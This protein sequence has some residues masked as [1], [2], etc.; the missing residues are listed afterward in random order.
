VSR[1]GKRE[2]ADLLAAGDYDLF[3]RA[4]LGCQI[5]TERDEPGPPSGP[6]PAFQIPG[7]RCPATRG[8]WRVTIFGC[9]SARNAASG[10]RVPSPAPA[11]RWHIAPRRAG[12]VPTAAAAAGHRA[13]PAP[14]AGAGHAR[15]RPRAEFSLASGHAGWPPGGHWPGGRRLRGWCQVTGLTPWARC[16]D[17][18]GRGRP[19]RLPGPVVAA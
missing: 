18:R 9:G 2:V 1:P 10:C 12:S 13:R 6:T 3:R 14:D 19:P 8:W 11:V 7:A 4:G 17:D 5:I 16:R 15:T